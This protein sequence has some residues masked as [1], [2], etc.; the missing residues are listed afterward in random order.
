MKTRFQFRELPLAGRQEGVKSP[1][2]VRETR[3]DSKIRGDERVRQ[4]ETKWEGKTTTTEFE[5]CKT[6]NGS[7][8]KGV[9]F[10]IKDTLERNYTNNIK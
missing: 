6:P 4:E 3:L 1:V 9:G 7:V 2:Q 5:V 10:C 8:T